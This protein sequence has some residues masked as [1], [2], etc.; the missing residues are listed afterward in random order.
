MLGQRVPYNEVPWFWSDQY[1]VNL[2]Y[3]GHH[4]SAEQIIVR[5]SLASDSFLAC[6]VNERRIDAA[7]AFNCGKDLRRVMPLIRSRRAI[8]IESLR[9]E[10]VDLRSLAAA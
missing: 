5:G 3:A 7:L 8:K 1:D 2:Q 6:Y 9:D 10:T 4:T